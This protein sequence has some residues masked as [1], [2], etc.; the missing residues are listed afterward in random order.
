M[1]ELTKHYRLL[2]GLDAAWQVDHVNLALAER[3]VEIDV[4]HR[5]GTLAC[6]ECGGACPQADLAPAA[7]VAASG[8][9][10]V[11]DDRPGTRS[12]VQ[13]LP[14]RRENGRYS[15]GRQAFAIHAVVRGFGRRGADRVRQR[16]A[17]RGAAGL[18]WHSAHAIIERA[19]ER[20]LARRSVEEVRQR[21]AS[22]KRASE[23]AELRLVMTDLDEHRVLDVAAERT[24]AAAD[25]L[26]QA[27]AR[28]SNGRKSKPSRPTCG[29]RSWPARAS[30]LPQA[31][32]VHDKFH[33]SKHLNEA[34]DQVRRRENKTLRAAGDDRLVGSKQLWLFAPTIS[35]RNEKSNLT[36]LTAR[37]AENRPGLGHQRTLPPLL[38][39]RLLRPVPPT[40]SATGT[41]GPSAADCKPIADKA[42]MLKRHLDSL[43]SYFRHRIT[44]AVSEGFNSRIQSHQVRRSRLSQLRQLP[45]PHPLLLR[46]TRPQTTNHHP[47]SFTKN[48]KKG[49]MSL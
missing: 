49:P 3:K 38:G 20:G 44:N 6:P 27:L 7:R 35:P 8:H 42:K 28:P 31:E 37:N 22:T 5:G 48:Q 25:T 13:V 40:S 14:V 9:D 30:M 43:L 16:Q 45:H 12:A 2:L 36:R 47:L 46:Q 1:N 23:R 4:S 34:V 29:S 26:W 10:A 33:V 18:D 41:A 19:V 39:L 15:L 32:I 17:G 11:P 21:R 24:Q